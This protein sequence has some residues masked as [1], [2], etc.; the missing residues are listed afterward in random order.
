MWRYEM[1]PDG[2]LKN[3]KISFD[4]NLTEDDEALDGM[5][6]DKEEDLFVSAPG[7]LWILNSEDKLLAKLLH[8]NALLTWPGAMK[9]ERRYI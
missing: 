4:W 6:V 8:L 7:G 2:T 5:R 1:Q 9:M 3:G